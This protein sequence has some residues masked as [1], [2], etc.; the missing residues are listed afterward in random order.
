L[1][2][3]ELINTDLESTLDW[4]EL[5]NTQTIDIDTYYHLECSS[6]GKAMCCL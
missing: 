3:F 5:I 4:F 2:W 6:P 1:D